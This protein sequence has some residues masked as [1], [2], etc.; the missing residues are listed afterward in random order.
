M[1]QLANKLFKFRTKGLLVNCLL[2]NN[3]PK[4]R[5]D[6]EEFIKANLQTHAD[7]MAFHS[8]KV[9]KKAPS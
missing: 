3:P 4:T 5:N 2:G 1:K 9:F 6:F 8:T 7:Y